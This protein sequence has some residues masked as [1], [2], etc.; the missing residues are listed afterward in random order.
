V[1]P[2]HRLCL[3]VVAF[4]IA[5]AAAPAS[6]PPAESSL[7]RYPLPAVIGMSGFEPCQGVTLARGILRYADHEADDP[8]GALSASVGEAF[9]LVMPRRAEWARY[10]VEARDADVKILLVRVEPRPLQKVGR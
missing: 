1:I 4:L 2:M 6:Q 7:G 8:T 3:L 9:S 5:F 10:V